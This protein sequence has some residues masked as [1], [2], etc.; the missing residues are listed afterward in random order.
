MYDTYNASNKAVKK[1]FPLFRLPLK[2]STIFGLT[3]LKHIIGMQILL[4]TQNAYDL[5]TMPTDL[6]LIYRYSH[7][8]PLF[9]SIYLNIVSDR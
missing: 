4:S 7:H 5:L 6:T 2:S 8:L 1:S 3:T 9:F